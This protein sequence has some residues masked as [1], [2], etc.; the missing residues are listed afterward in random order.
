MNSSPARNFYDAGQ[1][2]AAASGAGIA[3]VFNRILNRSLGW[4]FRAAAGRAVDLQGQ[5]TDSFGTLVY[6]AS[7]KDS[8]A[9]PV[10]IAADALACVVDISE[11]LDLASFRAAY[12]R[13][14]QVKRLKKTP[15]PEMKGVPHTTITLGILFTAQASVPIETLAE[16]LDRLNRQA[17]SAS[18]ASSSR[19][20]SPICA[21]S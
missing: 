16:E 19:K 5:T 8:P 13:I 4:P 17:S 7:D 15:A 3:V 21:H 20:A 12:E 9:E 2:L 18:F 10:E 11:T 6:T 14:A 1:E